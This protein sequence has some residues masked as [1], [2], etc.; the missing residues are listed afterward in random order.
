MQSP[1]SP[2]Q[3]QYVMFNE[4]IR[5][6]D[7]IIEQQTEI[8]LKTERMKLKNEELQTKS[9]ELQEVLKSSQQQLLCDTSIPIGLI[10]QLAMVVRAMKE[11]HHA[12][13]QELIALFNKVQSQFE[14][15]QKVFESS[16]KENVSDD[17]EDRGEE[18]LKSGQE[19]LEKAVKNDE[20]KVGDA[21]NK[22]EKVKSNLTILQVKEEKQSCS[23]SVDS[24]ASHSEVVTTDLLAS[25]TRSSDKG[26]REDQRR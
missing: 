6:A 1:V 15:Q 21:W 17:K 7:D 24:P 25:L 26:N 19:I 23:A 4:L 5:V 3:H 11:S 22:E 16:V 14:R 9:R 12:E 8:K 18:I 2:L 20:S 13:F 10:N